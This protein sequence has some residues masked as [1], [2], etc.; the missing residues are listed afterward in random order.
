MLEI[1]RVNKLTIVKL[2]PVG[3]LLD[4]A[5]A[6]NI[7]LPKRYVK[8]SHQPGH[9]ISVFV[10]FDSEDRLVASTK[11]PTVQVG[12]CAWLKVV[13]V[14][15]VGAFMDWGL[16]KDLLVPFAEQRYKLQLGRYCIVQV[17]VDNS[18]RIVASTKTNK[19]VADSARCFEVGQQVSILIADETKLGVKAIINHR[20]WGLLY[21]DEI[22]K[23][24]KKGQTVAAYI[25]KIRPDYKIEL[26]LQPIGYRKVSGIADCIVEKIKDNG[27]RLLLNDK[28]PPKLIYDTFGVSKKAFKQAVGA[29]YKQRIIRIEEDGLYL[30]NIGILP[31]KRRA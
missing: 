12:E 31:T 29:L 10:Y 21:H 27:G 7:L 30:T 6:G 28:S 18:G 9:R 5:D 4:A 13:A 22:F 26:S 15:R 1:G 11:T 19:V 23:P 14:T 8:Q 25:K 2:L 17:Y 3:A 16:E 24:I 20:Y